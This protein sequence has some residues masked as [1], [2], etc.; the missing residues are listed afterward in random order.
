MAVDL[1]CD[2]IIIGGMNL[3]IIDTKEMLGTKAFA[4]A[5]GDG[6]PPDTIRK[7]CELELIRGIRI[8]RSWQIHKSELARFRRERR[9]P[10]RPRKS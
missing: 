2:R 8:G 7:Y 5:L 4:E 3:A 1:S 10:G 9:P 6:T